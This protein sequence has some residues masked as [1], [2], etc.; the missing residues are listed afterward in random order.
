MYI[1]VYV[2]VYVY[3]CISHSLSLTFRTTQTL[4]VPL[5]V[6]PLSPVSTT[7]L[8]V[9]LPTCEVILKRRR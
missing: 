2:H 7:T 3:V 5:T 1:Y 6:R 4:D 9:R 8:E